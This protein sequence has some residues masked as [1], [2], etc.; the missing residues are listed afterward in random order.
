MVT[1]WTTVVYVEAII[2]HVEDAQ[3]KQLAITT[4]RSPLMMDHVVFL[5]FVVFVAEMVL[6]AVDV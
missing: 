4:H 5:M 1:S 3:M 6:L 2:L